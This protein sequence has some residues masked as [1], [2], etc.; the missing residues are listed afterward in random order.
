MDTS[1]TLKKAFLFQVCGESQ[2]NE[3]NIPIN[4]DNIEFTKN[5]TLDELETSDNK[6]DDELEPI[7]EVEEYMRNNIENLSNDSPNDSPN[8]NILSEAALI[9]NSNDEIDDIEEYSSLNT[10]IN[11]SG[12]IIVHLNNDV[13]DV[14]NLKT[15]LLETY[16]NGHKLFPLFQEVE[17][18]EIS[19]ENVEYYK[20]CSN[21]SM[22]LS[23]P[24]SITE[25]LEVKLND[26][27]IYEKL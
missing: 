11:I 12:I 5:I 25:Y 21:H 23:N 14:N 26:L 7:T 13:F 19:I 20:K 4:E 9:W 24:C 3:Y 10:V 6:I 2:I 16:I 15:Y 27:N 18:S 8:Q 1:L 22:L 17:V